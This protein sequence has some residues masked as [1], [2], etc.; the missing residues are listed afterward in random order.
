MLATASK[1]YLWTTDELYNSVSDLI[2]TCLNSAI[3]LVATK[4]IGIGCSVGGIYD[5]M[6]KT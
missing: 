6:A 1:S 5:T 4:S 3:C 2:D